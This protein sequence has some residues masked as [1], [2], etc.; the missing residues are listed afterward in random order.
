MKK[1]IKSS[2]LFLFGAVLLSGCLKTNEYYEGFENIKPLAD[3]PLSHLS[4]DTLTPYVLEV[5]PTPDATVDTLVAVHLSAKDHVGDVTFHLGLGDTDPAFTK[6]LE[7]HPEF[8]LLPANLYSFD[9]TVTIQNAGVLNTANFTVKFKSGAVDAD[10]NNLFLSHNYLLPIIIKDAGNYD[11]A[12]NFRMIIMR[13]LAANEWA[14]DYVI[15][16]T[17]GGV[18]SY[19]GYDLGGPN[20]LSTVNGTTVAEFDIGNFFGGYSEYTFNPDGTVSVAAY[21]SQGGSSYGAVVTSS[22]YDKTTHNFH[23]TFSIL[24]GKYVFPLTYTRQ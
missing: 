5:A 21:D 4:T 24:N 11:V 16:G 3:F 10:G 1:I 20:T 9:S 17:M 19:T 14:G 6:Y 23:V 15:S 13:P 2:I 8:E 22:D 12:S 7:D 18:N